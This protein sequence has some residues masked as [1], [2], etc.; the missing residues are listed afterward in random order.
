MAKYRVTTMVTTDIEAP[1]ANQAMSNAVFKTR[2][3]I[4]DDPYS[5]TGSEHRNS[6]V[7]GIAIDNDGEYM[8]Y[9]QQTSIPNHTVADIDVYL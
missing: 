8:V 9:E 1:N 4:G 7:T 6:W 2:I 3:M 5:A